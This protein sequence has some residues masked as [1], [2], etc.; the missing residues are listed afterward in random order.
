MIEMTCATLHVHLFSMSKPQM[1]CATDRGS[2]SMI[3]IFPQC[4]HRSLLHVARYDLGLGCG[5]AY[6]SSHRSGLAVSRTVGL[7]PV[8]NLPLM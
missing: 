2:I 4:A 7:F 1:T 5:L 3:F 6:Q 8:V